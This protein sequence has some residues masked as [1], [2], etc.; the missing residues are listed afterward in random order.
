MIIGKH[1]FYLL[2]QQFEVRLVNARDVKR[3]PGRKTDVE[4]AEWLAQLAQ[5]GLVSASFVPRRRCAGCGI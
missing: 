4:D 1:V 3:V 2:E 5:H